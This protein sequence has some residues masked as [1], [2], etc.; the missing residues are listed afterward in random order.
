MR[1]V[2]VNLAFHLGWNRVLLAHA[3]ADADVLLVCEALADGGKAPANLAALLPAGW[4]TMQDT[5]SAARAGSAVCWRTET[6]V[7]HGD[8]LVSL[9][10]K[11][12]GVR[13]RFL[14][15]SLLEDKATGD[16]RNYGAFHAPLL[17][18]GRQAE[19]Y[20]NF[21][22]WLVEHPNAIVGG[23][24]NKRP[25]KV[26]ELLGRVAVGAEVMALVVPHGLPV[27]FTAE[28]LEHMTDHP[29][30][31]GNVMTWRLARS[32]TQ[33]RT[34]VNTLFPA[35]SKSS[36]GSIGDQAHSTRPSDHNPN[37]AGV[38]CAID[39]TEDNERGVSEIVDL[40]FAQIIAKRDAR[41]KYLIHE[42]K[43]CRSYA[44]PGIPAWTWAPYTGT[45][46]HMVHGHISVVG[47]SALYDSAKP[48]GIHL[49]AGKTPNI[50]AFRLAT[51]DAE[52][53]KEAAEIVAGS[54]VAARPRAQAWLD[55][56]AEVTAAK[57]ARTAAAQ[58]LI[59]LEVK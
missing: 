17:T 40:I 39:I 52:R 1:V 34:E 7:H 2:P 38:V 55:A 31:R 24:G 51:T 41:V 30:I 46:A 10:R 5:S 18:T 45:N 49:P 57:S 15:H 22:E 36:D 42:G 53:R 37:A 8:G 21:R 50:T 12:V 27:T 16:I 20:R 6:V 23:D 54:N 26:G 35:R 58:A 4:A 14:A 13:E 3:C 48:W 43:I 25:A 32:L 11:G 47:T 28:H 56:D 19:F 59:A 29:V 9:S 33:L 44:K